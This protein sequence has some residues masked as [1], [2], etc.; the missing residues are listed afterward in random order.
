[1]RAAG[2]AGEILVSTSVGGV[3]HMAD[4]IERPIYMTKSGPA[5][6]PVAGNVYAAAE[7]IGDLVIVT[8]A[9]GTTFDVSLTRRGALTYTR[10]SWIGGQF[11]GDCLGMS[12]VDVRSIGAGGGS[13]AWIDSGGMLRVGPH[14]AGAV[15][16]PVCYG[17]GGTEAT[18]T[19]AAA[20]LGY[21]DPGFFLGGRMQ[22]DLPAAELALRELAQAA[23][24]VNG[25]HGGRHP[26]DRK[27][28]D[29]EGDPGDH[30]QPGLRSEES[31]IVA[32]GGSPGLSIMRIA[33]KLG[34]GKC[35]CRAR[36]R[37][38][39]LRGSSIPIS[40]SNRRQLRH[41]HGRFTFDPR[42]RHTGRNRRRHR[43]LS[44]ARSRERGVADVTI[45]YSVEARYLYQVW[46]LESPVAS[47]GSADRDVAALVEAFHD[48]HER[49][50]AVK[51]PGQAVECLN[52]KARFSGHIGQPEPEGAV[53][54]ANRPGLPS[55]TAVARILPRRGEQ[56]PGVQRPTC[57]GRGD[58]RAGDHRGTDH[59]ARCLSGNAAR[60]G[61]RGAIGW[62]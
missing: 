52:W 32:G 10:E 25:G 45:T 17:R 58:S 35:C 44:P 34:C 27:R 19:D 13:I 7:G 14:S 3:M 1:M 39:C 4:V 53:V 12:S 51:Q 2:F 23:R 6:A 29:G 47:G 55:R 41:A 48:V 57:R 21:L 33:A 28:A 54:Q 18:V 22:L 26:G 9:G 8:D 56:T 20:V 11:T 31:T 40:P 59:N 62:N 38:Q 30:R 16:G 37:A 36:R 15:P 61:D 60:V 49:V 43:T 46:E 24:A 5:M 50:F 42:Q